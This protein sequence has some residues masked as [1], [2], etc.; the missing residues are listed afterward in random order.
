MQPVGD[1]LRVG[2]D[3]VVARQVAEERHVIDVYLREQRANL[4]CE[5][6]GH[7]GAS[8]GSGQTDHLVFAA[9]K[10]SASSFTSGSSSRAVAV[11]LACSAA[12]LA[13]NASL[14]AATVGLNAS[15]VTNMTKSRP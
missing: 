3:V 11:S 2:L 14:G 13:E 6:D 12:T 5:A 9:S 10:K 7:G 4:A 1:L 8:L 15:I